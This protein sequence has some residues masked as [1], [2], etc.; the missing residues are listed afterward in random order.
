MQKNR[1]ITELVK[2][3][4]QGLAYQSIWFSIGDLFRMLVYLLVVIFLITIQNMHKNLRMNMVMDIMRL[5]L[6][7]I[8]F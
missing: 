1:I 3:D 8:I 2:M 5:Q 4:G 6:M 7:V